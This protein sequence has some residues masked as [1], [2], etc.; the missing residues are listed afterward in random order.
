[1][2]R[3][4]LGPA[5]TVHTHACGEGAIHANAYLVESR[6]GV[7]AIDATLT[8]TES[9]ALRAE[10]ESLGKPLLAVLITHPHPDHV[11]G[12]TNLV[13][14]DAP[15]IVATRSVLELM[16]RLEEPKRAQWAP[17]YGAEWV[18]RWTHPN[19]IVTSGEQLVLDDVRYSVLD[20]G[21]GGDAEANSVWL[22][23]APARAAFLGDLVFDGTHSYVADGYV[24]AWL[25]NLARVESAV[26]G[27]EIVFP[28]H[29]TP[30]PPGPLLSA[31]RDYL[32]TFAA[33]VKEL[34]DGSGSLPDARKAEIERRMK[35]R[36]PDHALGFL[37]GLSIDAIARELAG[38]AGR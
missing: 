9:A 35:A 16:R 22:V 4:E 32:L 7:V 33:H 25:A 27:M 23:E 2:F 36:Y 30:R 26:R 3:H 21:A 24:L 15:R 18:E 37:V 14:R 8:R 20:L 29:G 10:L 5:L 6:N 28:G 11:A 12:V 34:S 17:V 38:A 31:Q 1:M 13:A 19:A